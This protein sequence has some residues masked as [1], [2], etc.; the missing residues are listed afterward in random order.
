MQKGPTSERCICSSPTLATD[1][2]RVTQTG[3]EVPQHLPSTHPVGGC[4]GLRRR[5]R[6]KLV[7]LWTRWVHNTVKP[8]VC[9]TD[10]PPVPRVQRRGGLWC[11]RQSTEEC[12]AAVQSNLTTAS[13]HEGPAAASMTTRLAVTV[14]PP[15]RCILRCTTCL[16][17]TGGCC[18]TTSTLRAACCRASQPA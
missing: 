12:L 5:L 8:A 14:Q 15:A 2:A 10:M 6:Q 13:G 4:A 18:A 1:G 11:S 9:P 16:K 7:C 17:P 3:R